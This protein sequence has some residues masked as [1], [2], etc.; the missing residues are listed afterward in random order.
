MCGLL[1]VISCNQCIFLSS[2]DSLDLTTGQYANGTLTIMPPANTPSGTDITLTLEAKSS[3][4]V[5][6]NYAVLRFSV[7]T[8]VTKNI[9]FTPN[10]KDSNK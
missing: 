10:W 4:G 7:V 6:S 5:D 8:K 3:S 9:S 2:L 1:T